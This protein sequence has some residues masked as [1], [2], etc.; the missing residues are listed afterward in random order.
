MFLEVDCL[1]LEVNPLAETPEG[2]IYTADA[3]LGFDDNA[4][5]RQKAIFD[6]EDTTESDPRY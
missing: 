3:K 2:M 4:Q 6:M 1:Q 5:Y